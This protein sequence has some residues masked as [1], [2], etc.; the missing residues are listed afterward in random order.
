[1]KEVYYYL[2]LNAKEIGSSHK[3]NRASNKREL[4]VNCAGSINTGIKHKSDN[5]EGRL[6]YYLMYVTDG[7]NRFFAKDCKA[8]LKQGDVIILPPSTGYIQE[9]DGEGELNYLWVHFTGSG[10]DS[11]LKEL[12]IK[13]YPCVNKTREPNRPSVS[14]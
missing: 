8:E 13:I 6:D 4:M 11:V 1:M 9:F 3:D 7:T 2:N 5:K 12:G 10:V 14:P